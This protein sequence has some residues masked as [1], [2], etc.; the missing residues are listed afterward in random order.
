M[1]KRTAKTGSKPK[2]RPVGHKNLMAEVS[3][4]RKL[5]AEKTT[6]VA[7]LVED[8]NNL[9]GLAN[10]RLQLAE[11]RLHEA[12]IAEEKLECHEFLLKNMI[13]E[14]VFA[15]NKFNIG[16]AFRD[17]RHVVFTKDGVEVILDYQSLVRLAMRKIFDMFAVLPDAGLLQGNDAE[18][19]E[20]AQRALEGTQ[21]RE[22]GSTRRSSPPRSHS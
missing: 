3:E 15:F 16:V 14:W 9:H 19:D 20:A 21:C 17:D 5:L 13:L 12:A 7:N 2:V 18:A 6:E 1:A 8:I 4:L 22:C 11:D 10:H